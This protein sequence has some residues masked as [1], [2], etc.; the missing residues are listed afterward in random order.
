M[1][2]IQETFNPVKEKDT[3]TDA[4]VRG[5]SLVTQWVKDLT[6]LQQLGLLLWP[7]FDPLPGNFHMPQAWP[8]INK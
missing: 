6:S 7:R 8:K 4:M 1:T 5:S 2:V 3:E